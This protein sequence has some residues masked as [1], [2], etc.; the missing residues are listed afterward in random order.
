LQDIQDFLSLYWSLV[1]FK[2]GKFAQA[3]TLLL[4]VLFSWKGWQLLTQVI[5][6]RRCEQTFQ[7][8]C[9]APRPKQMP[10]LSEM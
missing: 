1:G 8:D 6:A 4:P 5:Y 2:Q 3:F 7:Q 10:L 9:P